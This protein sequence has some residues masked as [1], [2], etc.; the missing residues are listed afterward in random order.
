MVSDTD[1]KKTKSKDSKKPRWFRL[2]PARTDLPEFDHIMD[3]YWGGPERRITGITLRIIGVNAIALLILMFGILYLSQYQNNLINA[4]LE[5]FQTELELIS[6]ALSE[7]ALEHDKQNNT[8]R[9]VSNNMHQ[10]VSKLSSTARQRIQV[11]NTGGT[12]MI[13]SRDLPGLD[14]RIWAEQE[15][16]PHDFHSVEVLR[17]MTRFVLELLPDRRTLPNYP[18][19]S[20]DQVLSFPDVPDALNKNISLSVWQNAKER[21]FLSAAAPL[22][23]NDQ[24]GGAVLLTREGTEIEKDI[25]RVWIDVLKIFFGTLVLTTLLSIYLSGAIAKPLKRLAKAAEKVR[26]GQARADDIPDLSHRHD[27]IGELSVVLRQM[28]EALWERMDSI[29]RFAADVSH[30]LKN[31]LTSLKSAVET[32]SIVKKS[33]DRKKLM[34]IIQHDVQRLDRLI[35][36]ISNASRIDTELS[37][38]EFEK[39]N[40]REL[41]NNL[42]DVYAADP[43]KRTSEEKQGWNK[44]VQTQNATITLNNA[45][46]A[47]I[48]IWGLESR[49]AQ[50]FQ[51]LLSN[52]LSF[53]PDGGTISVTVAPLNKKIS[54]TVENEG[55]GI[56]AGK[57]DNIFERF[58]SERPANEDYGQHSGLGL[59]ICK[60]IIE[61]HGGQ[62]FAENVK[63]ES[64]KIS[65]AR[66]SVTLNKA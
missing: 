8:A 40:L 61:A 42:L 2:A 11:F 56:P 39:I 27:E 44:S 66:L 30:E 53:T 32:A 6:A 54:I 60:Q 28:T 49:L 55:P 46:K 20:K 21:I 25:G 65:G 38:E 45:S 58:Y 48:T 4:R 47:E 50:V 64:G 23:A 7:N 24:L 52:A 51:N 33:G 37:R 36:D 16:R 14:D 26:R 17:S 10:M 62:I 63:N 31:P 29:E 22:F 13:D 5:T 12:L 57:L 59:S 19:T 43:L 34:D 15:R 35:T 9:I 41:L 18:E 3:L 1:I